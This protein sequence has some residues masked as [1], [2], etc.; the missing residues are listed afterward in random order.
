MYRKD[1]ANACRSVSETGQSAGAEKQR[2]IMKKRRDTT[3]GRA[4]ITK[5]GRMKRRRVMLTRHMAICSMRVIIQVLHTQHHGHK[6]KE[7]E[8][9]PVTPA[10]LS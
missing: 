8:Y 1:L 2:S 10:L 5:R 4:N 6:T 3:D 7:N 9:F